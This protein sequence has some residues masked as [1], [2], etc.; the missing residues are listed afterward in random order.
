M[1]PLRGL[2]GLGCVVVKLSAAQSHPVFGPRR[3]LEA[4]SRSP[5]TGAVY[6]V[7]VEQMEREVSLTCEISIFFHEDQNK[8]Q[9][10]S[11]KQDDFLSHLLLLSLLSDL[12]ENE[13]ELVTG[14]LV[15]QVNKHNE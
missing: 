11:Y 1:F 6:R 10:T 2:Q 5:S 12:Q 15:A 7:R 13:T 8:N 14:V 3:H 4:H 9:V